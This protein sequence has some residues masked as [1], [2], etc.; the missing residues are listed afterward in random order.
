MSQRRYTQVPMQLREA[1]PVNRR[2]AHTFTQQ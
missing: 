1:R 2:L